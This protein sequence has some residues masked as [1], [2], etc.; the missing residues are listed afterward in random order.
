MQAPVRRVFPHPLCQDPLAGSRKPVLTRS[1]PRNRRSG[2]FLVPNRGQFNHRLTYLSSSRP[3]SE[4]AAL[5][6][7]RRMRFPAQ[8]NFSTAV[9]R[10]VE[11]PVLSWGWTAREIHT[12]VTST[13][14][15]SSR[16]SPPLATTKR[17][18][19]PAPP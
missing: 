10:E 16:S 18:R 15:A 1:S 3:R 8:V 9:D 13:R 14:Q 2:R 17:V 7:R 19:S 5:G 11:N 4:H 6:G 12:P